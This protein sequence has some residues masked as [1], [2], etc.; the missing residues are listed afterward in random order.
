[1]R[2]REQGQVSE[3]RQGKGD[4]N[5]GGPRGRAETGA[6]QDGRFEQQRSQHAGH[7]RIGEKLPAANGQMEQVLQGRAGEIGQ[8]QRPGQEEHA[9]KRHDQGGHVGHALDLDSVRLR[10]SEEGAHS[11]GE[12][13]REIEEAAQ[14][15][16]DR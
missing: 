3:E 9:E 5:Q 7:E 16:E 4:Q 2:T 8:D 1:M 11:H 14:D 15:Q 12:S 6:D 10:Q 13:D